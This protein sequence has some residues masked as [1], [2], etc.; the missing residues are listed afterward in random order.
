MVDILLDDS[1]SAFKA[2]LDR[3]M[4]TEV[5]ANDPA[6]SVSG[7][8]GPQIPLSA[9]AALGVTGLGLPDSVG[10]SEGSLLD[11]CVALEAL[12]AGGV[13]TPVIVATGLAGEIL[14]GSMRTE[15]APRVSDA[16]AAI[17]SGR[18]IASLALMPPGGMSEFDWQPATAVASDNGWRLT[19]TW[20]HVPYAHLADW[21][22]VPVSLPGQGIAVAL[23]HVASLPEHTVHIREQRFIGGEPRSAV[24]LIDAPLAAT[25]LLSSEVEGSATVEASLIRGSLLHTAHA[26]GVAEGALQVAVD[27]AKNR[28][29]FGR[30][31]GSFQTVSN[32]L[33][34]VRIAVDPARLAVWEAAWALDSSR[35]D[36][37][38]LVSVAKGL[39][40]EK[41]PSIV[42]NLHQVFGAIGYSTEHALHIHTRIL[43]GF[44]TSYGSAPFHFER[45]STAVGLYENSDHVSAQ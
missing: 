37:P 6:T 1:R 29:Q 24:Q 38:A 30:P 40:S 4:R 39:L 10:G 9:L 32:R 17:A 7:D 5:E 42:T 12:G 14:A 23:L 31:I 21:L 44:Q 2:E 34:D 33:A 16:L 36:A 19:A 45:A 8:H 20:T 3:L 25:D 27:W 22:V 15:P 18:S 11:L 28:E 35:P 43:K 41:A 13:S 26:V